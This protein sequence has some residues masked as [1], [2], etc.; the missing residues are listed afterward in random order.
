MVG[1][2]EEGGNDEAAVRNI[3]AIVA[4]LAGAKA[5]LVGVRG[6]LGQDKTLGRVGRRAL[7]GLRGD[8]RGL[9]DVGGLGAKGGRGLV[10]GSEEALGGA[11]LGEA[12][13][14]Q[15]RRSAGGLFGG[16]CRLGLV[17][18]LALWRGA[19]FCGGVGALCVLEDGSLCR[20]F[21]RGILLG[22]DAIQVPFGAGD[23]GGIRD[24]LAVLVLLVDAKLIIEMVVG[25]DLVFITVITNL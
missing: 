18:G 10:V 23:A 22:L 11:R 3:A 8:G 12:G 9:V 14:R 6:R 7:V 13:R 21:G 1:K 4:P 15:P 16:G 17:L 19:A 2:A 20:L 5:V 25:D 24:G